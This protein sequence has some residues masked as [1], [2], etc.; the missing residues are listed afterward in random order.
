MPQNSR[1]NACANGCHAMYQTYFSQVTQIQTF[2][3]T[4]SICP[5]NMKSQSLLEVLHILLRAFLY[6]KCIALKGKGCPKKTQKTRKE[7]P[8]HCCNSTAPPHRESPNEE[9]RISACISRTCLNTQLG[10]SLL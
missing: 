9:T 6:N 2:K 3:S 10:S 1:L 5:V 4:V 7:S 8:E